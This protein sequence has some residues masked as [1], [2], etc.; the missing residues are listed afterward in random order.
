LPQSASVP[1]ILLACLALVLG[2][3]QAGVSGPSSS[4][5]P[6]ATSVATTEPTPTPRPLTLPRP[7]DIPSDGSCEQGHVCLGL[8][9]AGTAYTTSVFQPQITFSVPEAGWENRVDAGGIFFLL[10]IAYPGDSIAFFRNPVASGVGAAGIGTGVDDLAAW[11]A[12]NPLFNA[13]PAQPVTIGGLPGL[14]MDI[15]VA[16]GAENQ[17]PGCP[18]QVCVPFLRGKDETTQP[19]WNW[20]WG[21]AGLETQRL[22]LLTS[23]E[24]V[25]AV[26]VDSYD[27]TSFD[28]LTAT[29]DTILATL[30]FG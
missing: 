21:F 20:D 16:A 24:G 19:Q 1:R 18:V 17:D 12:A 11:L 5:V 10:P 3:C 22:Y 23:T 15:R 2:A 6:T 4:P 25:L 14:S 13:T 29:A 27:G 8:L 28:T 9:A 26:F 7:T 30:H